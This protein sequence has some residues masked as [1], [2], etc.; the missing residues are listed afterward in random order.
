MRRALILGLACL[1][2]A[3]GTAFAQYNP[4]GTY[5]GPNA[6][7]NGPPPGST[8]TRRP[9]PVVQAPA[10]CPD[11]AVGAYAYVAAI[12]GADPLGADEVALQWNVSN[13]GGVP[14]VGR[15]ATSQTLMLEY[16]SAAGVQQVASTP[17]PAQVDPV[18]GVTLGQGQTWRGYMRVQL[19]PEARRRNLRLRIGYGDG[20]TMNDCNPANNEAP[21][22]QPPAATPPPTP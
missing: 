1:T 4:D 19:T 15:N 12:P 20:R 11:L 5:A 18:T 17:I 13:S 21:V 3:S 8:G 10:A 6:P 14:Y 16:R 22:T 7:A 2:L 9:P